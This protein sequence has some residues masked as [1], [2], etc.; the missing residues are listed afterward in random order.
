[1]A[2][3]KTY[4]VAGMMEWDALLPCGKGNLRVRFEGGAMT[5]FGFA[6]AEYRTSNPA[7]QHIIEHSPHFQEGKIIL[8]R[9]TRPGSSPSPH[10]RKK[11]GPKDTGADLSEMRFSDP[12]SAKEFLIEK[13][14][15]AASDM[16][17]QA[18]IRKTGLNFGLNLVWE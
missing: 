17:T 11:D 4:G 7:A 14:G 18:D 5:G 9:E 15:L 3:E 12:H 13:F 6:P 16:V 1:M 10:P 8:L 2:T